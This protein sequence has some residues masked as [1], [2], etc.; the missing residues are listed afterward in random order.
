MDKDNYK[1]DLSKFNVQYIVYAFCSLCGSFQE[2]IEG[3]KAR[4]CNSCIE[5]AKVQSEEMGVSVEDY[6]DGLIVSKK[7]SEVNMLDGHK[8]NLRIKKN[9]K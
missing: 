1:I 3:E 6:I 4:I 5:S 2:K 9:R 7:M 8:V